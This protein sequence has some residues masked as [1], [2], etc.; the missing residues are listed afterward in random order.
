MTLKELEE[1][2]E[3]AKRKGATS[4]SKVML[5]SLDNM[6]L[7]E[8][9]GLDFEERFEEDLRVTIYFNGKM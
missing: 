8:T 3:F 5:E 6:F 4:E 7:H 1:A 9:V 2:I